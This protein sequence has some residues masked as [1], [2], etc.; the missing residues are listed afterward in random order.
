MLSWQTHR[1]ASTFKEQV[2]INHYPI[3][4]S[5]EPMCSPFFLYLLILLSWQT[6]RSASTFKEQ[7]RINHCKILCSAEPMCSALIL[8]FVD[9]VIMADTQ[10]CLYLKE[11]ALLNNL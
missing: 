4:C 9:F 3:L 2:R 1:S 6:R 7:V 5:G 10:V 8:V 11:Y